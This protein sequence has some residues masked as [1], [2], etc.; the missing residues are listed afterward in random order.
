MVATIKQQDR[1]SYVLEKDT[2]SVG[3][4]FFPQADDQH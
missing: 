2:G 1:V 3:A 4:V